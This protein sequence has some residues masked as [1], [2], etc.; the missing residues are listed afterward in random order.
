[1]AVH[2]PPPFATPSGLASVTIG[3]CLVALAVLNLRAR[4]H[5]L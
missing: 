4:S 1:V 2:C 5:L 3:Y